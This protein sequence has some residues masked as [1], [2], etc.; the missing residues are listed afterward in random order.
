MSLKPDFS[1][2]INQSYWSKTVYYGFLLELGAI[3]RSEMIKTTFAVGNV[4]EP[5]CSTQNVKHFTE[6]YTYIENK[7]VYCR[8]QSNVQFL[9]QIWVRGSWLGTL[10]DLD[11]IFLTRDS[12]VTRF[13]LRDTQKSPTWPRVELKCDLNT[14]DLDFLLRTLWWSRHHLLGLWVWLQTV[15]WPR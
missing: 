10:R 7:T 1:L 15:R 6:S 3:K 8:A 12:F 5:L 14:F 11:W 2:N 4:R 9:L 13:S